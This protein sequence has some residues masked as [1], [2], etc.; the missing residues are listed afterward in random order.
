MGVKGSST[1][2]SSFPMSKYLWKSSGRGWKGPYGGFER[3]EYCLVLAWVQVVWEGQRVLAGGSHL[4]KKYG[5]SLCRPICL[6][7][8]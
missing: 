2:G 8:V 4:C 5:F 7:R 6:I 1:R 3:S